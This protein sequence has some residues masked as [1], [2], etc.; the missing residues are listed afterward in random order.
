MQGL[1]VDDAAWAS[2]WRGR[3]VAD[4]AALALGLVLCAA[5]LPAWPGSLLVTVVALTAATALARTPWPLLLRTLAAPAA[6]VVLGGVSVAITVRGAPDWGV[7]VTDESVRR[8]LEVTAHAVAG[9]SAMILLAV[10]TPM[11]DL[12][13]GLRRARV[14]QACVDVA[15]L[16]YRLLFVLLT[17]LR[18]VRRSQVA[19][20]GYS[21]PRRSMQSAA[22][23]TAAVLTSAWDRASRLEDGLA[24]RE[25]GVADP[26][27][28]V[29][30]P[31]SSPRFLAGA[32]GVMVAVVVVSVVV[33]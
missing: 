9:T 15:G 29:P 25:F 11:V 6:F 2:A 16:V 19:R 26:V 7:G 5:V 13:A 14:P 30:P 21:T 28:A 1:A 17:S 18:S 4:K 10:T 23:L 22:L 24:G 20:L 3:A 32:I 8:A 31:R 27:D 33:S 12:L